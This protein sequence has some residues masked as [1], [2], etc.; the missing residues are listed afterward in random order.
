MCDVVKKKK[1]GSSRR[2]AGHLHII[3]SY[4]GSFEDERARQAQQLERKKRVLTKVPYENRL[5]KI[6]IVYFFIYKRA[7]LVNTMIS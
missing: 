5:F 4:R 7:A 3:M 6:P 2:M 1:V